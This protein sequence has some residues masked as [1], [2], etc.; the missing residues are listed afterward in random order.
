M[1]TERLIKQLERAVL[2]QRPEKKFQ[3]YC[4]LAKL[5]H[6]KDEAKAHKHF[7]KAKDEFFNIY[8][9]EIKRLEN[10]YVSN[11]SEEIKKEEIKV[12]RM[13]ERCKSKLIHVGKE[14]REDV[15][16]FLWTPD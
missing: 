12:G 1:N 7:T 3:A 8:T 10:V 2:N 6:R 15:T 9:D 4:L 5:Y 14:L 11:S 13:L 16:I